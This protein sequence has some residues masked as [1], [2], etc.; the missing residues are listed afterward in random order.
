MFI[1]FLVDHERCACFYPW[2]L[3]ERYRSRE[4]ERRLVENRSP[5]SGKGSNKWRA[6]V[7][8]MEK[9]SFSRGSGHPCCLRAEVPAMEKSSSPWGSGHRCSRRG[10]PGALCAGAALCA[11]AAGCQWA[12]GLAPARSSFKATTLIEK[13]ISAPSCFSSFFS[14]SLCW[15]ILRLG[16]R[17]TLQRRQGFELKRQPNRAKY[18]QTDSEMMIVVFKMLVWNVI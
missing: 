6:A 13:V 2:A 3:P 11:A 17:S 4:G 7:P 18:G 8:A 14:F 16:L 12:S 5:C 10:G 9:S 15:K 1:I